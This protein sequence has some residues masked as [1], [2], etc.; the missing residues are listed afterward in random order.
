MKRH[1]RTHGLPEYIDEMR[2]K[3]ENTVWPNYMANSRGVDEFLFKGSANPTTVQRIGAWLFGLG[4]ILGGFGL[5]F[6]AVYRTGSNWP[7][8]VL[9]VGSWALGGRMCYNG[10]RRRKPQAKSE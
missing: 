3:Q 6:A 4:F 10:S 1:G 7:L 8:W 5:M 9:A 2:T